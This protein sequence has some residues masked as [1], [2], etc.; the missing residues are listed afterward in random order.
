[1]SDTASVL[2]EVAAERA[3]QDDQWGGPAHDDAHGV[4][5][6]AEFRAQYERRMVDAMQEG[7]PFDAHRWRAETREALVKIAALCVAQ[8]ESLDRHATE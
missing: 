3:R 7:Q 5:D 6:W 2:A 1:M 4:A 8:V